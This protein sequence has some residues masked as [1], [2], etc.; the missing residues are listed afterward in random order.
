[1]GYLND[2]TARPLCG[3]DAPVP[4]FSYRQ[5]RKGHG[6]ERMCIGCG[7]FPSVSCACCPSLFRFAS[8]RASGFLVGIAIPNFGCVR[9]ARKTC[10]AASPSAPLL[11]DDGH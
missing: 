8:V 6:S 2:M 5:I 3:N 7:R 10:H 4:T 1:M 9:L 11:A